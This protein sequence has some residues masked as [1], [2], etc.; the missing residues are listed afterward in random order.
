MRTS[1]AANDTSLFID[2]FQELSDD[3]RHTLDPLDLLLGPQQLSSQVVGFIQ[4]ILL[5]MRE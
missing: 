4:D 5:Q 3:Q 2:R 1:S